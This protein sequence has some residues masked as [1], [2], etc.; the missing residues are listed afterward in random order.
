MRIR[1]PDS[2][3]GSRRVS[4]RPAR[5]AAGSSVPPIASV[6]DAYAS[7][8]PRPVGLGLSQRRFSSMQCVDRRLCVDMR[9]DNAQ[10][11]ERD[12]AAE[13]RQE[14][15]EAAVAAFRPERAEDLPALDRA[16]AVQ[17]EERE[18]Q[19][20]LPPRQLGL[21]ALA[22]DENRQRAGELDF[23]TC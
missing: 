13:L 1:K 21:D 7:T 12:D 23:D 16:Q 10:G 20:A 15:R 3:N 4:S 8:A 9:V 19:P 14:R 2:R 6:A 17:R 11:L 18:E 22:V 5:T